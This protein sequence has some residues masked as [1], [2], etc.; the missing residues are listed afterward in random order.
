MWEFGFQANTLK[1][2]MFL[3]SFL[4]I[5]FFCVAG[6]IMM[7]KEATAIFVYQLDEVLMYIYNI[8]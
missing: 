1:F 2:V 7:L 5:F 6:H 3:K 4:N 8:M